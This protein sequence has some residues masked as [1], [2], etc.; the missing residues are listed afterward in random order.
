MILNLFN[1]VLFSFDIGIWYLLG[2]CIMISF[3]ENCDGK[4]EHELSDCLLYK[5]TI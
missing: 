5:D 1:T 4:G 2:K 3:K